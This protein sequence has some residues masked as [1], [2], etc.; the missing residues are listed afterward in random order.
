MKLTTKAALTLAAV[1]AALLLLAGPASAGSGFDVTGTGGDIGGAW[2]HGY[3]GKAAD[4]RVHLS[5]ELKDTAG[6]GKGAALKI[7]AVYSDGGTR[8]EQVWNTRGNQ[9]VVGIGEYTFAGNVRR[10][11]LKECLLYRGGDGN[12]YVGTCAAGAEVLYF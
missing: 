6:D 4:G 3:Y 11:E 9:A 12:V 8:D 7:H 2:A 10:I 1:P 5:G